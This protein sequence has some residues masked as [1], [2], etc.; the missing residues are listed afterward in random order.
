MLKIDF[1][2]KAIDEVYQQFM[3][4]PSTPTKKKLHVIYLKAL[5]LAHK[6]IERIARTSADS[7]TRYLKD[8]AKGGLNALGVSRANC[9]VSSLQPPIRIQSSRIF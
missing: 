9:P 3:A 1:T 6:N 8:Y 7:V 2:E 5:G 4:H